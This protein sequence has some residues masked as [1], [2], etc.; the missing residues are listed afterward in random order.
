MQAFVSFQLFYFAGS[1]PAMSTATLT[2]LR[3]RPGVKWVWHSLSLLWCF[4]VDLKHDFSHFNDQ[5]ISMNGHLSVDLQVCLSSC[6]F[7]FPSHGTV[8]PSISPHVFALFGSLTE[9]YASAWS[10]C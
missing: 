8:E 4:P 3:E 5:E 6:F 10:L 7:L 9:T 1:A 2:C